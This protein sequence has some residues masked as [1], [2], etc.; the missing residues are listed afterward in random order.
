MT[1]T[2]NLWHIAA[3][4]GVVIAGLVFGWFTMH[5]RSGSH[6][7]STLLS[8]IWLL[9]FLNI[10]ACSG[11]YLYDDFVVDR[12]FSG[13]ALALI[14]CGLLVLWSRKRSPSFRH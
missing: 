10:R 7:I 8:G 4:T 2:S 13:C 1:G 3:G 12:F 6:P 9:C 5:L 11:P 14:V